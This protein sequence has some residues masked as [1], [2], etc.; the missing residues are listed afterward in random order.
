VHAGKIRAFGC[1]TFPADHIV[2]AYHIAE[3]RG[4]MRFRTEQPP[5]SLLARGIEA[6]V[7]PACQRLG[8]GVLT[9]SPLA[10]GL[11]SGKYRKGQAIDLA[12]GRPALNPDRF[13]PSLPGSAAKFEAIEELVRLAG[14]IGCSL[15]QLAVAFPVAHPAITSVIIGPRTM[16]QLDDLLDGA[17]LALDDTALDRIDQIVPPGVN[18]YNPDIRTPPALT[19]PALR[20]RPPAKRAAVV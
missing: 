20:R 2:D 7:L 3:R 4:L 16:A 5:Y 6:A 18:L 17:S 1:S 10:R 19:D 8:M 9:W 11:L 12:S 15:P 14:E 13:N